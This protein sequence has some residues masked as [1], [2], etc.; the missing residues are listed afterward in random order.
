MDIP[1]LEAGLIKWY[2]GYNSQKEQENKFGFIERIEKKED[3]FIHE[4]N[5]LCSPDELNERTVVIFEVRQNNKSG[6]NEAIKVRQP[7]FHQP[8]ELQ[9][10][11]GSEHFQIW[12]PAII[13]MVEQLT[14]ADSM[15]LEFLSKK[16]TEARAKGYDLAELMK[17]IPDQVFLDYQNLIDFL[18]VERYIKISSAAFDSSY[19]DT[20]KM[21]LK[22]KISIKLRNNHRY[23]HSFQNIWYELPSLYEGGKIEWRSD[24]Y[25]KDTWDSLPFTLLTDQEIWNYIPE[26]KKYSI[27]LKLLNP[28]T[29][30]EEYNLIFEKVVETAKNARSHEAMPEGLKRDKRIFPFLSSIEQVRIS[31]SLINEYWVLMKRDAKIRAV[32]RA[33]KENRNLEI[34]DY[35]HTEKDLLVKAVLLLLGR[36]L[37]KPAPVRQVHHWITEYITEA[38]WKSTEP[39]DLGP[40]LPGCSI[41]SNVEYCEARRWPTREGLW[42]INEKGQEIAYCPRQHGPCIVNTYQSLRGAHVNGLPGISWEKWTL[43]DLFESLSINPN[44]N[45]LNSN[46]TYL[47][48][49]SGWVNRLNEIRERMKCEHCGKT[50]IPDKKY[51]FNPAGYNST[52]AHCPD[53]HG[54]GIYFNH[55]SN[56]DCSHI[57]DSRESSK[58]YDRYYIC[59][60]CGDIP[61]YSRV[62]FIEED[63]FH[64]ASPF[65]PGDICPKCGKMKMLHLNDNEEVRVCSDSTCNH[66]IYLKGRKTKKKPT[67]RLP[68]KTRN[69]VSSL[70]KGRDRQPRQPVTEIELDGLPW[71]PSPENETVAIP[72][73]TVSEIGL[74]NR[75]WQMITENEFL[76][77]VASSGAVYPAAPSFT[78]SYHC[79]ICG[80][81]VANDIC[82]SC[83]F[84]WDSC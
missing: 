56:K 73:P 74:A 15:T 57:I 9:V 12:L 62:S 58:K 39:L 53:G 68:V 52:V 29:K 72:Q 36:K 20:V 3:L 38:A 59:I 45:S 50:L 63:P 24:D 79:D 54:T 66:H 17:K 48:K 11:G 42:K 84:D 71:L 82:T 65:T 77:S 1:T 44:S 40:I 76:D 70:I 16:F 5:L 10:C 46:D 34:R 47:L 14:I 43:T 75:T 32:F 19:D 61:R 25:K 26:H 78:K 13:Q 23:I 80:G 55:C 64:H 41:L 81:V 67:N 37:G 18:P 8:E 28:L 7:N 35:L 60:L 22:E 2:G 51:A 27:L 30:N 49:I 83:M 33:A 69:Y 6:K 4:T 31:W 21:E